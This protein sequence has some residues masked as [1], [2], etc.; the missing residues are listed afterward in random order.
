MQ[1]LPTNAFVYLAIFILLY[2]IVF[3]RDRRRRLS[4]QR[5]Y[6]P[7]PPSRP[8]IGH[9]LDVPKDAPWIAYTEMS[10]IYGMHNYLGSFA[11]PRP[12]LKP[13]QGDVFCLRVVSQVVVVLSSLS[14]IKD[15]LEKRGEI[16]SDRPSLRVTELYVLQ[17]FYLLICQRCHLVNL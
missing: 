6:P 4:Y 13:P 14:A 9:L 8:I 17:H 16:Y 3:F 11:P 2:L 15:L 12:Q 5:M 7:G 1:L 10:R